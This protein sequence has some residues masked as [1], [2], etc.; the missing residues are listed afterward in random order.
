MHR[1]THMPSTV[2]DILAAFAAVGLLVVVLV[3]VARPF[4]RLNSEQD[5]VRTSD[6]KNIMQA[7]LE[8]QI[9][10]SLRMDE[11]VSGIRASGAPLRVMIGTAGDC[12]GSYGAECGDDVLSNVCVDV[13]SF[14]TP[15]YLDFVPRDPDRNFSSERTGY[16]IE[17]TA[18][19]LD[20]GACNPETVP[21][22]RLSRTFE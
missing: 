8:L 5:A 16:Y 2:L 21:T 6:V 22:I 13:A 12:S 11:L 1:H 10:D 20:V 17:M 7:M 18:T 15:K 14:L 4:L 19:S 3:A 9:V